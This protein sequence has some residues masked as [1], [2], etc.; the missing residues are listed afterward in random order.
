MRNATMATGLY[1]AFW[2]KIRSRPWLFILVYLPDDFP[3]R[4]ETVSWLRLAPSL[5]S[6]M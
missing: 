1:G 3:S 4:L 6:D 2:D 5:L